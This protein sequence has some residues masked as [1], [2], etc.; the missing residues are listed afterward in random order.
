VA[1]LSI[2]VLA[3]NMGSRREGELARL[4]VDAADLL[5]SRLG[6]TRRLSAAF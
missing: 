3:L 4:I 6:N 2:S 5:S 1:A